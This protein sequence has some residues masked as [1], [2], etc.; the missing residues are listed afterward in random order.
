MTDWRERY[1]ELIADGWVQRE[2]VDPELMNAYYEHRCGNCRHYGM[3]YKSFT[4][5]D[6]HKAFIVCL[7]CN[8]FEEL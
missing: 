5:E 1:E 8:H 3:L 6:E 4:R 2:N 7:E